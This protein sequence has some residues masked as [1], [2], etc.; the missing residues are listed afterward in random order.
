[1]GYDGCLIGKIFGE[2]G[3][4]DGDAYQKGATKLLLI[5]FFQMITR[6][7]DNSSNCMVDAKS[8]VT[9]LLTL[10]GLKALQPSFNK[11]SGGGGTP[12][13]QYNFRHP[14]DIGPIAS[15]LIRSG[16]SHV[17]R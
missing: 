14:G 17:P 15:C 1:M 4:D 10:K 7:A 3:L 12:L 2:N 8:P 5:W 16:S 11:L 13:R 6:L 9:D